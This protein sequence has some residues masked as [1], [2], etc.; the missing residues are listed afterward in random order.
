MFD[1]VVMNVVHVVPVVP[2]IQEGMF[3]ETPLP[4]CALP[5]GMAGGRFTRLAK[6]PREPAFDGAPPPGVI[7]VA[8]WQGP[9]GVQVFRQ[10]DD[11]VDD[12]RP[13]AL[14]VAEGSTQHINVV[15]ECMA[16][17]VVQG[18]G[19]KIGTPGNPVAAVVNHLCLHVTW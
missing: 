7:S 15:R 8:R 12:K 4:Q 5:I 19:E 13:A 1:R 16:V 3:P 17:T 9:D 2:C 10:D 11:S 14:S 18:N 6:C